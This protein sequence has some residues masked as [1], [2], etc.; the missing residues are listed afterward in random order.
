MIEVLL[1]ATLVVVGVLAFTRSIVASIE[2]TSTTSEAARANE[3]AR[4]ML[5]TLRG[6]DF[7]D[8]FALFNA[9]G[10]DDPGGAD[11]AP[12][13]AFAV[14][15]LA[16]LAN[17]ADGLPGEIVFPAGA[18]ASELR[19]DVDD[20]RLG[21]PRDLNGDGAVDANDHAADYELL[22]VL[23]RV[24]WRGANGP[25]RVELKTILADY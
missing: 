3:A 21:M 1:A 25:G 6:T 22:P 16:P 12:G 24:E 20:L 4:Q 17:D 14:A 10:A 5:E 23:V 7:D 19:E 8:V 2:T 18:T 11:S 15:G 9:T 13:A